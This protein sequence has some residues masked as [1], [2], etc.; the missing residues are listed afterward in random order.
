MK[1]RNRVFA[2]VLAAVMMVAGAT[3]VMAAG[4]VFDASKLEQEACYTS[5][6]A[7]GDF[8]IAGSGKQIDIGMDEEPTKAADGK[9]LQA[10]AKL[11]GAASQI[12]FSAKKGDKIVV[13]V[14]SG[15]SEDREVALYS[16][17][18]LDATTGK[19]VAMNP[20]AAP[21]DGTINVATFEATEDGDYYVASVTKG[22]KIYYISV[23]ETEEKQ[24]S[25]PKTGVVSMAAICGVVALAGAGVAVVTR[26]KEN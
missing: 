8:I 22:I 18:N 6:E 11:Q 5:D 16:T 26:K 1:K 25:V 20:Q 14:Q 24:D 17:T 12:K 19:P 2:A 21:G 4:K 7:F 9:E 23:G 3:T 13:Y 15:G 10:Y